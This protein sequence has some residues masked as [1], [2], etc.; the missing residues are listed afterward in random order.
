MYKINTNVKSGCVSE[1]GIRDGINGKTT[2]NEN[3]I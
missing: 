3:S 2:I 1:D